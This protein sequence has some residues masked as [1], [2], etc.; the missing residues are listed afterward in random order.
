MIKLNS[1]GLAGAA[2]SAALLVGCGGDGG[3]SHHGG[4]TPPPGPVA[5]TI[6]DVVAYLDQLMAGTA[7]SAE[8]VDTNALTLATDDA[9]EPAPLQ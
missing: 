4:V 1:R 5:Q 2:L 7:D 8:P 3:G 6:T 9:S